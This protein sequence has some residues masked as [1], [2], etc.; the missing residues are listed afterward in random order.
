[1]VTRLFLLSATIA[2]VANASAA[3]DPCQ[4]DLPRAVPPG[5]KGDGG[6]LVVAVFAPKP[7]YPKYARARH[8]MGSGC[9]V[10]NVDTETGVVKSVE[11]IKS[12]GH[13]ILDDE[14]IRTFSRWRF[15]SGK[16]APKV[17]FPI[18]FSMTS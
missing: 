12:T 16:A 11:T 15:Q 10:M 2:L 4:L 14:V 3:S 7:D 6:K 18:T 5:T 9:F 13:K 8:W 1:M 17:K